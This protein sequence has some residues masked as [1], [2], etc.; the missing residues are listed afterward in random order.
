MPINTNNPYV[1]RQTTLQEEPSNF[2]K[3]DIHR[4]FDKLVVD[5]ISQ[6]K[7]EPTT[8]TLPAIVTKSSDYKVFTRD[9]RDDII[10]MKYRAITDIR[11]RIKFMSMTFHQTS[12]PEGLIL[13]GGCFSSI[14]HKSTVKD[15]DVFVLND[16]NYGENWN[17]IHRFMVTHEADCAMGSTGPIGPKGSRFK[18][19]DS[20]YLNN[21]NQH[22]KIIKTIFDSHSKVQYIFT[23]FKNRQELI[24]HF[25]CEHACVSIDLSTERLYISRST[26]DCI[27]N[28]LIRRHKDNTILDWRK[29]KF[30]TLGWKVS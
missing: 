12:M 14:F 4:A 20:T 15:Y 28:K 7:T 21:T 10:E 9:E 6:L 17:S 27:V 5:T 1:W 2:I 16:K 3:D 18:V 8:P 13:A 11:D 19:G 23:R 24:D 29:Q 25:D 26:Y 30:K 22:D